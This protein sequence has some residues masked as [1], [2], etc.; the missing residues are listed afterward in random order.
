MNEF[1][2]RGINNGH[3][4]FDGWKLWRSYKALDNIAITG[5]NVVRIAWNMNLTKYG[6]LVQDDLNKIVSSAISNKLVPIVTV[7]GTNFILHVKIIYFFFMNIDILN[8]YMY[9]ADTNR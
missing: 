2:M 8:F 1:I 5:S 3:L 9:V 6:G 7:M 4:W